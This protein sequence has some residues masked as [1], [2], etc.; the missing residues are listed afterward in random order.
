MNKTEFLERLAAACKAQIERV[1]APLTARF[2]E[3]DAAIKAIPAGKDGAPGKDGE[4][5]LQGERGERGDKGDQG[6]IGKDG[7]PGAR[8]ERGEKGAD[9]VNG[10]DGAPGARGEK[11]LD[12]KDGRDGADGKSVAPEVVKAIVSEAVAALPKAKD[13]APG[14]DGKDGKDGLNG[15]NGIDGRDALALNILPAIDEKRSYPQGTFARHEGGIWR[16]A[17]DT[18]GLRGWECVVAGIKSLTIELEDERTL[19]VTTALT[20][21]EHVAKRVHLLHPIDRG[22]YRPEQNYKRGDGVSFGGSFWIA[23]V[24][25]SADKP[26]TS[27]AWR[28]A[29]KRGRDGKDGK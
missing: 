21:A 26:G 2:A 25:D 16:A 19:V 29:V 9:G 1:T 17:N 11:G 15:R 8:G 22:V 24:D 18:L 3:L 20:G 27:E 4:R 14:V 6:L 28:L 23:Q 5:G 10:K 12:G 13:G 7:A